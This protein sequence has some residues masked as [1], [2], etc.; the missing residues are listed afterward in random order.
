V[1]IL[2]VTHHCYIYIFYIITSVMDQSPNLSSTVFARSLS[3]FF[4]ASLMMTMFGRNMYLI[5]ELNTL[6]RCYGIYT[7]IRSHRLV[8][9]LHEEMKSDG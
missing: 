8:R 6:L 2:K 5:S 7:A 9:S 1:S 3:F 4:V